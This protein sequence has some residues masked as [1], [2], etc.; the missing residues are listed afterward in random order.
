MKTCDVLHIAGVALHLLDLILRYILESYADVNESTHLCYY[1]FPEVMQRSYAVV[2]NPA[3]P[4]LGLTSGI[5]ILCLRWYIF[6]EVKG[7]T[8]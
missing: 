1:S 8:P 2:S 6:Y 3:A 4:G 5:N 7:P